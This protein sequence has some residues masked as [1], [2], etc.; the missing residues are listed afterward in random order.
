MLK[1][2][3][4]VSVWVVVIMLFFSIFYIC[5][6]SAK[7]ATQATYYV[8]PDGGSDSNPGTVAQPFETIEKAR[9]IARTIN[10][11]M[12]GDIIVYLRG[13]TY[14]LSSTIDFNASDSGTNGY[15]VIYKAYPGE[16]PVISGGTDLSGGWT[17]YDGALN[18]YKKTG[19]TGN[20]RQLYVEDTWATRARY[21]NLTN[22]ATGE[23]YFIFS[24][25]TYPFNISASTIGSWAESSSCEF[26]YI[27]H[28]CQHRGIIDEYTVNGD[29]ATITFTSPQGSYDT[30]YHPHS[31]D[32]SYYY[33][34]NSLSLLD[35]QGEWFLDT[36]AST[37]YYIPRD[38]ENMATA[39]V[40]APNV[41][42][43]ITITGT[44][45]AN[46][47]NIQFEGITFKHSNWTSPSTYGY[48]NLQGAQGHQIASS[49]TF[50]P[51]PGMIDLAYANN[52][53]VERNTFTLSGAWGIMDHAG[54]SYNTYTGNVF[55]YLASGAICTGNSIDQYTFYYTEPTGGSNNETISNNL[56]DHIGYYYMDSPAINLIK[57]KNMSVI[58]NEI[59]NIPYTGITLGFEWDDTGN[60]D[61]NNNRISYNRIQNVRTLLDDGG[62]IYSL[63]KSTGTMIDHNYI[64]GS[65]GNYVYTP[66]S[67]FGIYLDN[68][69]CYKTVSNNVININNHKLNASFIFASN[70]P[71]HDNIC[72]DNF[73]N[74]GISQVY[75]SGCSTYTNNTYCS[76]ENWPSAA[77]AIMQAAGIESDY[78]DIGDVTTPMPDLYEVD[79][80]LYGTATADSLYPGATTADAFD[81]DPT[82]W[83]SSNSGDPHW[84]KVDLGSAKTITKFIIKNCNPGAQYYTR[85]YKIQFSDDGATNWTDLVIKRD[86][87]DEMNIFED[88]VDFTSVTKRYFRIYITDS[89]TE[90]TYARITEFKICG[91]STSMNYAADATA[92]ADSVYSGSATTAAIDSNYETWW[93]SNSSEPHWMKLDLGSEKTVTK[94]V[95]RNCGVGPQYYT[96]DYKIQYS[97]DGSS[98][99][100]DLVSVTGN[101]SLL[102]TFTGGTD[103]TPVTKRYYRIYISESCTQDSYARIAEFE[104][105]G[106]VEPNDYKAAW[107]L[108]GNGNDSTG[109]Y[110]AA[111]YGSPS[112]NTADKVEGT[113]SI[114]LTSGSQ[115]AKSSLVTTVTDDVTLSAWVKWSGASA[116][117][118]L[119]VYNGGP[120]SNGY[121]IYVN[122]LNGDKL[123]IL[124]GGNAFLDTNYTL[125]TGTW[126]NLVAVRRDGTW[127]LYING[128]SVEVRENRTPPNTPTVSTQIGGDNFNGLIDNVKIYQRALT[129]QEIAALA[130]E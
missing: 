25:T 115:Y 119:I 128:I 69:S 123:C 27:A 91:P 19:V 58:H 61:A 46:V 43:L 4:K 122:H 87:V 101:T 98:G 117:H 47:H 78:W 21:P 34:E 116:G 36:S 1:R 83:W 7:A 8:D 44:E 12:T 53:T 80:A 52:I 9:D 107:G 74:T 129:I 29:T 121:G 32:P 130:A 76:G 30:L 113:S 127:E 45:N 100:T 15:N 105:W 26:V 51:E 71:N 75:Y 68:G 3:Y 118:Q 81:S 56:I 10:S 124:L 2:S 37:L 110:N 41:E 99:W 60:Q 106:D 109:N 62:A 14:S 13:G 96:R 65:N 112:F 126:T 85:E 5:P 55:Q 77:V 6:F 18:I 93:S 89:C 20:F 49:Y 66:W 64:Y 59:R 48:F 82:T 40:I 84:L 17:L 63:G 73:Y 104:A 86:N 72:T 38:G 125:D 79:Y 114:S 35:A 31:Q 97:N 28:W 50:N 90:D 22:D 88:G 70:A 111:L 24:D 33:F 57:S 92:T 120:G 102:N 94:F 11:N 108:N 103:F 23:G 42:K 39:N 67:G 16:T 95:V 54:C